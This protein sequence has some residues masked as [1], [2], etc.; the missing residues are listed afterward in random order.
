MGFYFVD[1]GF[2]VISY[3]KFS[4]EKSKAKREKFSCLPEGPGEQ[5]E[6]FENLCVLRGPHSV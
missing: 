5:S 1:G 4:I 2:Y 6:F 3:S